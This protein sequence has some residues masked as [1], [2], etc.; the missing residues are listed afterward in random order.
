MI[1]DYFTMCICWWST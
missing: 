1:V